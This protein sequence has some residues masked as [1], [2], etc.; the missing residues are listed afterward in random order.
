[1]LSFLNYSEG[2]KQEIQETLP[3]IELTKKHKKGKCQ[4]QK[5]PTLINKDEYKWKY[6]I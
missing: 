1:M 6:L 2:I 4:R 3:S 5:V